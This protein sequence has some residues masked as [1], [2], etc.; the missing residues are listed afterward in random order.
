MENLYQLI[1]QGLKPDIKE[2]CSLSLK[3]SIQTTFIIVNFSLPIQ[4]CKIQPLDQNIIRSFKA[5][6]QRQ[7]IKELLHHLDEDIESFFGIYKK[8]NLLTA[9]H[10]SKKKNVGQ[11]SFKKK[12]SNHEKKSENHV[13]KVKFVKLENVES[14]IGDD[15]TVI[16]GSDDSEIW[17]DATIYDFEEFET[18]DFRQL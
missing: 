10:F 12:V 14:E 9:M 15:K 5:L 4:K 2:F 3:N 18:G 6:Y 8:I 7:I 13:K 11:C 16:Y 1:F 17:D